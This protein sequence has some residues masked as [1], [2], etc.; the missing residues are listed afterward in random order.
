ML[1][2]I[3]MDQYLRNHLY[4]TILLELSYYFKK[5]IKDLDLNQ[6]DI[7]NNK[8]RYILIDLR[9]KNRLIN[10]LLMRKKVF[11]SRY[12]LRYQVILNQLR[13]QVLCLCFEDGLPFCIYRKK[14]ML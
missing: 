13:K 1:D 11:L 2:S 10:R 12:Y 6:Y 14:D 7:L 8:S 4:C 3:I 5:Y 9:K